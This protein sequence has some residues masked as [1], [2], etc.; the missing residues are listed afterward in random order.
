MILRAKNWGEFQHYKDRNPTWIKLHKKLLDDRVFQRLPDASRALAPMVWLICSESQDGSIR[1]AAAEIAFRLRMTEKE[2]DKALTPLI[3]NGFFV[4]EQDAIAPLSEPERSASSEKRQ[5]EE[6]YRLEE[7]RAFAEFVEAARKHDW[8]KPQKLD[9]ERRKKIRRRLD[10][11]GF[12]GWQ[13]MLAKAQASEF[14]CSKFA[15]KIDWVLEPKNFQ[16]VIEGNYDGKQTNGHAP[17]SVVG[18]EPW[19]QR[20]RTYKPGGFWPSDW[21]PPPGE[22]GCRIPRHHLDAWRQ[23]ATQ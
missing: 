4:V 9:D 1:D 14:L 7:E 3:D 11:H 2:A 8:P 22:S 15:L 19:D 5:K 6:E 16:K 20:L 13:T 21:G 23:G 18:G 17:A 12:D 10:E